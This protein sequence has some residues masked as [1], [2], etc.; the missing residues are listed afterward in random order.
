M[1][2]SPGLSLYAYQPA[3]TI[4]TN[5][6]ASIQS[7]EFTTIAPGGF[8]H[9]TAELLVNDSR[10]VPSELTVF[11][12]IALIDTWGFPAF[13][14]RWDEPATSLDNSGTLFQLAAQGGATN[15][16]DDP[17]D[18]SY[19]GQ[20]ALAILTDQLSGAGLQRNNT[21]LIDSDT[22]QL[23]LPA[24]TFNLVLTGATFEDA[25]NQLIPALGADYLYYVWDHATHKDAAGFPKWQLYTS[26]R[27][28]SS[29]N[30]AYV[31]TLADIVSFKITP[32][33]EYAFNAVTL[34]YRDATT[35]APTSVTVTDSRLG[36]GGT[37]GT[38]PFP[39][40]RTRLDKSNIQ[41]ASAQA[42]TLANA[43]LAQYLNAQFK[44]DI[45]LGSVRDLNGEAIPL[46]QVRAGRVIAV[47]ELATMGVALPTGFQ[48]NVNTFFISETTYSERSGSTPTVSL[49][50][51]TYSDRVDWQIRRLEQQE[52][53][54]Q[55]SLF[56]TGAIQQSGQP[57]IGNAAITIPASAL[58]GSTWGVGVNFRATMAATPSSIT[59]TPAS[60]TNVA[61]IAFANLT[62]TGFLFN[63]TT[64]A[65]GAASWSGTYKTVGN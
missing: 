18:T 30:L 63:A 38:A 12:N 23:T 31:A 58:A 49:T 9:L 59:F 60:N 44:I 29:A 8:G 56:T 52:E 26:A 61:T 57:E 46:W 47:P 35:L 28:S 43:L 51:N 13:L 25:L 62:T 21:C 6:G 4:A 40:R 32:A 53:Q 20:T 65:N 15:L 45:V 16:K 48:A 42:A 33:I 27:D 14:G 19:S 1:P 39:W 5:Y 17:Q 50:S 64:T 54:R 22:S 37:Q 34:K 7:L 36:A 24:G 10:I 41:I 3:W 2:L 55:R 11:S